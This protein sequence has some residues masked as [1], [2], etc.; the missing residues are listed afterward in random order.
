M[1][2]QKKLILFIVVSSLNNSEMTSPDRTQ[3]ETPV[4]EKAELRLL[5]IKIK[6][7]IDR[8][9]DRTVEAKSQEIVEHLHLEEEEEERE[10]PGN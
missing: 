1:G 3:E 6:Q 10:M 9:I 2:E 8:I 5:L 4:I 7:C